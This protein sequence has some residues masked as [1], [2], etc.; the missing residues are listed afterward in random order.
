LAVRSNRFA[1]L[2]PLVPQILA[3]IP[4]LKTGEAATIVA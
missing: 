1:D 4:N 3:A 2:Q